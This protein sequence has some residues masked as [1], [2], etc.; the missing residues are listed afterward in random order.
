[1]DNNITTDVN[2]TKRMQNNGKF[3]FFYEKPNLFVHLRR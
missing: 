3:V 2:A 1:M